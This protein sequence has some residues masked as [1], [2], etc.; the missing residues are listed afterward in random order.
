MS[1]VLIETLL[2]EK[3]P[4]RM[5]PLKEVHKV[6]ECK[7]RYLTSPNVFPF[8]QKQSF[9]QESSTAPVII[10]RNPGVSVQVFDSVFSPYLCV[11]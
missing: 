3:E 5:I 9:V 8:V 4:L 10:S 1:I 7:Q 2:Q 11:Q 6:Q